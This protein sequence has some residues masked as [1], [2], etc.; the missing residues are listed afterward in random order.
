[1]IDPGIDLGLIDPGRD[2]L[3]ER[4][5]RSPVQQKC[6]AIRNKPRLNQFERLEIGATIFP[7]SSSA[8]CKCASYRSWG[9]SRPED[10]A[11][12]R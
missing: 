9:V 3:H 2:S 12:N 8:A 6:L 11:A 7:T 1:M 5:D 4:N 10:S